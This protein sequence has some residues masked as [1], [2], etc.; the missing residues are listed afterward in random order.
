MA[1]AAGYAAYGV[2]NAVGELWLAA[3]LS[4]EQTTTDLGGMTRISALLTTA[5]VFGIAGPI[6][7]A[8]GLWRAGPVVTPTST[9]TAVL[10]LA[11]IVAI[12]VIG[13]R[14]WIELG[15]LSLMSS[16]AFFRPVSVA[17]M[18][19]SVVYTVGPAGVALLGVAAVRAA[20]TRY[21]LPE[22]L[23]AIGA[24]TASIASAGLALAQWP[25]AR[26]DAPLTFVWLM[27]PM[28][29]LGLVTMALG[30]FAAWISVP[31]EG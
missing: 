2:L 23:V 28:E 27:P 9:R 16:D 3:S 14:L 13:L 15:E 25:M 17:E 19:T 24:F 18:A 20:P 7:A 6:S 31:G 21:L 8:V 26:G 12:A 1:A 4:P 22:V 5:S 29:L 10:T 30:F 11:A